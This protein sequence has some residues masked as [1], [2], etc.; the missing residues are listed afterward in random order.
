MLSVLVNFGCH[1]G[2]SYCVY[3][4]NGINIETTT[5]SGFNWRRLED[6]IKK[7]DSDE[8]SI[9]GGGDPLHNWENNDWFF[10]EINK[11]A[12]KYNK[13]LELHTSYLDYDF[14]YK[15]F[16]RVVFHLSSPTQ[17]KL[18]REDELYLPDNVRVVFVVQEH[19]SKAMI[20]RIIKMARDNSYITELVS[21]R[22]RIKSNGIEDF[23]LHTFL[24]EQHGINLFYVEQQDYNDYFVNNTIKKHYLNIK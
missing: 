13:K 6:E 18:I 19:F 24:K 7:M 4:N 14:N 3:K 22:Q 12:Q 21:F 5:K 20:S 11:L 9:S 23:T 17:I 15:L 2:C 10:I 1:W 16:N 8:I